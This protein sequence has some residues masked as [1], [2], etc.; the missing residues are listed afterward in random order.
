MDDTSLPRRTRRA[1][2]LAR[3][4]LD[5]I[6]R[7]F[8]RVLGFLPA[9]LLQFL[10]IEIPRLYSAGHSAALA[11]PR[12]RTSSRDPFGFIR[13]DMAARTYRPYLDPFGGPALWL[14]EGPTPPRF[15][16]GE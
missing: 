4:I 6:P 16:P 9:A 10:S 5:R 8:L 15:F 3:K 14:S 2:P 12:R 13:L 11:A 1:S 7:I